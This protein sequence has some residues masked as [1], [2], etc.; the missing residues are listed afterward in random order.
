MR[1]LFLFL[2]SAPTLQIAVFALL[3]ILYSTLLTSSYRATST[4]N[5]ADEYSLPP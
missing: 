1:S 3:R 5:E 4:F 2:H